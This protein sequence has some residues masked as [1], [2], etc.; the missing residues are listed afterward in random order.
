MKYCSPTKTFWFML[1]LSLKLS[2]THCT[3]W[4]WT[5]M[6]LTWTFTGAQAHNPNMIILVY[7]EW[8]INLKL[9]SGSV[10]LI[11]NS[12]LIINSYYEM[13]KWLC[14]MWK[15][16]LIFSLLFWFRCWQETFFGSLS[17][18]AK[19]C[20]ANKSTGKPNNKVTDKRQTQLV[21]S[22]WTWKIYQLKI[23]IFLSG[24]A[25]D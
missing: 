7:L 4:A 15:G 1:I 8:N 22:Q 18:H 23:Q 16:L 21:I 25:G 11:S 24:M 17:P 2:I 6:D 5:N 12:T 10:L 3:T 19:L 14:V 13:I 20:S 9:H